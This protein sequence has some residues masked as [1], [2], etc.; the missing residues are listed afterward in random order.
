MK[1]LALA[2]LASMLCVASA[3]AQVIPAGT[4]PVPVGGAYNSSP[5]TCVSGSGCWFQVDVNG[6]LKVSITGG[7]GGGLSVQDQAAF[8]Q[9]T[10]N[11]TPNGGVFNDTATLSSGQQGTQRYT[12]KRAGLV[13]VDTNG[14]AL[15][16]AVTAPVPCKAAATWNASTGLTGTQPAGCDGSAAFW[17]DW[18]AIN[19][20]ALLA[21][22]GVTG[23][24]SP[25]V[26]VASDNTPFQIKQTDGTTV[27]ITDPCQGVVKTYTPINILASGS[28]KIITGTSAKKTYICHI[29]IVTNAANNVALT[30][31]TVTNCGTG[32]AGVAGGTTAASGWNF[33][34]N[35]G[36]SLGNGGAA[37]IGTA[38]NADDI[39]LNPSVSTQLS[40]QVVWVQQ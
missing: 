38:T 9:G 6:N 39:C 2:L 13:D 36:I 19:G 8:T 40:G 21:G 27:V 18:G 11:F 17:M 14:N 15:Y 22:N 33:S 23:T 26:T 4:N 7:G 20:V 24:G 12:T 1:R 28:V 34:A 10:S 5:P 37:V 32:T 30:E 3:G 16:T 25:R 31:G 35:G 29:D